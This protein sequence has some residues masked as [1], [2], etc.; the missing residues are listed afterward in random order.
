[1]NTRR[2]LLVRAPCQAALA[3]VL[4]TSLL[5]TSLAPPAH[6]APQVSGIPRETVVPVAGELPF[7]ELPYAEARAAAAAQGKLFPVDATATW[8]G[9]CKQMEAEVLQLGV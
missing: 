1:M 7:S 2:Q 8:C 6:A 5:A 9:P 4:C 3:A